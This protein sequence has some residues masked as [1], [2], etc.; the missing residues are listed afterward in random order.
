MASIL[1]PLGAS[2]SPPRVAPSF[3]LFAFLAVYLLYAFGVAPPARAQSEVYDLPIEEHVL[4][5]G[6][7][8]LVLHRPGDDRVACKIFTDFGAM[9]ERPGQLGMAHFLEH[10]MFKGT[11]TLGTT[12]WASERPLR[13]EILAT[14][15]AL[16]RARN[17]ARNEI[18]VRQV[19]H[20]GS[21][22]STPRIDS[23]QA[24]IEALEAEM[25]RFRDRGVMMRWYQAYGGTNLTA[26]TEQEY[27]KFD[28][29]LPVERVDLFLRV[30][31]D[32][33]V[34]SVFREFDEERMILVEQRYG[35]LNEPTTP[36]YEQMNAVAGRV[37]PVFWPEGYRTDFWNYTRQYAR[38]LYEEWFVPNNTTLVFV[39]G[40][41]LEEMIPKVERW[42]GEIER[43]PE[44]RRVEA[45]EPVPAAERRV[46]WRSAAMAPRVEARF[47]VPGVGHPDR[48]A[49]DVVAEV[50]GDA[51]RDAL[52]RAGVEAR[53][54]PNFLVVHTDRFGV[55]ATVNFEVVLSDESDLGAAEAVL[56]ETLN[57]A[58]RAPVSSEALA[59]A[60]KRLR[61][62]WHRTAR[63]SD[64]LAFEIG[65]FQ[66]MDSWR[67]LERHLEGREATTADDVRRLAGEYFVAENRTIGVVRAPEER[68]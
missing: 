7:R 34:N 55:P 3:S 45:V 15:E 43:A 65:H 32:R 22:P 4:E 60:K 1:S 37:H 61:A 67:T 5:N 38:E 26:S 50:V 58:R 24:E 6:L 62:K 48:P 21:L 44:P 8:I 28:I 56:V 47:L 36:Y 51:L 46:V 52:A 23:L 2:M 27:M 41:T 31:A 49:M 14:E 33:M 29:N 16:I 20:D 57:R 42:F 12:D 25:A 13:E 68:R 10:L 64:A 53:V 18:R 9:V 63:S 66:V 59:A 19:W 54:H 11:H 30:E 40:V 39:G 17:A 35:D